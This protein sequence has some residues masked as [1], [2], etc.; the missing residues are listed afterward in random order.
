MAP[1]VEAPGV[2][3][4]VFKEVVYQLQIALPM[5]IFNVLQVRLPSYIAHLHFCLLIMPFL[6]AQ[7][8]W[9]LISLSFAGHLGAAELAG[10]AAATSLGQVTG[11][12][13]LVD[14]LPIHCLLS[15]R[16]SLTYP[17]IG[18]RLA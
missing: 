13:I 14:P 12:S 3:N 10:A 5:V 4:P 15:C 2:V 16:P 9:G 7:F 11:H 18:G 1:V 8:V 6:M 17:S